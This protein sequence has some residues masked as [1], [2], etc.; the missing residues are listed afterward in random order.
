MVSGDKNT[1]YFHNRAT[2]RF[3]RNN[4]LELRPL[5]GSL[6]SG[7]E[8]V[9]TLI[10][11]YFQLL[12]TSSNP[13]DIKEVVQHTNR[14]GDD[15]MNAELISEF[16]KAE[17]EVALKQMAPLNAPGL[18]GMLPIFFQHYWNSIGDDV[19]KAVLS[20]LN[21]KKILLGLNHT[22]ITLISKVKSPEYITEFCPIALCNILYK[23]VSKVLA[24]GLKRVLPLIISESQIA[25]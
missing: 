11:E 5:D 12:F 9:S 21:S 8:N 3:Q 25:F 23:L 24:N 10:V 19:V 15:T 4:I 22:F 16:T 14:R 7:D 17:V 20:C 2:Q 6:V 1:S 18:D 13:S